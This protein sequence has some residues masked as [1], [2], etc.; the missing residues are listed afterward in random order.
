MKNVR[1]NREVRKKTG[2]SDLNIVKEYN[3]KLIFY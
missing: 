3:G 1:L 2:E